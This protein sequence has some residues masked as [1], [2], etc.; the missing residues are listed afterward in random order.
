MNVLI[1]RLVQKVPERVPFLRGGGSYWTPPLRLDVVDYSCN[2]LN[3]LVHRLKKNS[4][5]K[6]HALAS[7]PM[8]IGSSF[9]GIKRSGRE[10]DHSHPSRTE[11]KECGYTS[12]PPICLYDVVLS[13]GITSPLPQEGTFHDTYL[14]DGMNPILLGWLNQ[15]RHDW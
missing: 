5:I 2:S 7:Y 1:W 9:P 6:R 11:G 13:T 8:G 3:I 15:G 10:A 4:L 12:N 14:C